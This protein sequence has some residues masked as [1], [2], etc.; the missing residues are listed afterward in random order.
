MIILKEK[1]KYVTMT[2]SI[3]HFFFSFFEK[4]FPT[5]IRKNTNDTIFALQINN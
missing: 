3:S 2:C 1:V 5:K 4:L